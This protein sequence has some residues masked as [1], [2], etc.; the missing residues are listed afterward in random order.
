MMPML[1]MSPQKRAYS[2]KDQN[3][4]IR[5]WNAL[6][7]QTGKLEEEITLHFPDQFPIRSPTLLRVAMVEPSTIP[8]MCMSCQFRMQ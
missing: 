6:N 5:H 3:D 8:V 2:G 7:A 4:W 1:A